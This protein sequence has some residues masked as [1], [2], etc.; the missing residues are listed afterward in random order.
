M[1]AS[2]PGAL[3]DQRHLVVVVLGP[4]GV[5]AAEHLRPVLALGAAGAGVHLHVGVVA[6]GLA[7]QQGFHLLAPRLLGELA[8]ARLAFIDGGVVVL[9]LAQL[10]QRDGIVEVALQPLVAGHRPAPATGVGA[11]PSAPPADCSRGWG[12]RRACSARPGGRAHYPSQRCLRSSASDWRTDWVSFSAS[13][14]MGKL[15]A[16]GRGLGRA[17]CPLDIR[18]SRRSVDRPRSSAGAG[19]ANSRGLAQTTLRPS[20]IYRN[21]GQ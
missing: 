16:L 1:P 10:D 4:A 9:R 20:T 13:G 12:P 7:R 11:L 6:V 5:H 3:L 21:G 8:Q 17:G 2:S 19:T 15:L 18:K 14:R